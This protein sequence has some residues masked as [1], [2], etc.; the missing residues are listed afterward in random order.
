MTPVNSSRRYTTTATPVSAASREAGPARAF[1]ALPHDH[2]IDRGARRRPGEQE[3]LHLVA[4]GQPQQDALLL[5]LHPLA[6]HREAER[7][8]ER[9]DRLDDDAAVRRAAERG[10]EF[11]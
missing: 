7:A 3:P 9:H 4:A 8:A 6:Q 11:L 2:T 1:A 10:D 5:R